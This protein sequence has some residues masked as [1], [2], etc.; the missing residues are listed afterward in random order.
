MI[1]SYNKF[2]VDCSV[3]S[4]AVNNR[5]QVGEV[6]DERVEEKGNKL[7]VIRDEIKAV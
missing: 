3:E 6:E 2:W 1:I 4:K 7:T 5:N